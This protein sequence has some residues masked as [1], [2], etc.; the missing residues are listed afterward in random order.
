M[1]PSGYKA[2]TRYRDWDGN[3]RQVKRH[4]ATKGAARRNL[5]AAIRDRSSGTSQ[6]DLNGETKLSVLSEVWFDEIKGRDLSPST[7]QAYRDRLDKQI[8]PSLG[9]LRLR[10]LSVGVVDRH[11]A[12]VKAAHGPSLAKTT[13]SVLSGLFTLACRYDAIA[14]NPIAILIPC[15][16]V[17]KKDGSLSGYRWG[18]K[19]KRVLLA[20]EQHQ[21]DFRLVS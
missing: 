11:L 13:R 16:R 2:V 10:E 12:A 19:R 14:T 20:R 4:G 5:A 6:I 21:K 18:T 1:A 15:H 9:E 7:V 17:V 3:V 8:L